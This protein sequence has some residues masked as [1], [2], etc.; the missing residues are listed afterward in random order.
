ML[1][2]TGGG[3]R[4]IEMFSALD[5]EIPPGPLDVPKVVQVAGRYGVAFHG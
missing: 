1:E 2:V 3:S 5:R 4:A